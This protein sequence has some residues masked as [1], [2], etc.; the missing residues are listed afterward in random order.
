MSNLMNL[1]HYKE[2]CLRL[3]IHCNAS[4]LTTRGVLF[5]F[6]RTTT[7]VTSLTDEH[8]TLLR[9]QIKLYQS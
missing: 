8:V 6:A 5:P 1:T 9:G 3:T 4:L 2:I 7:F